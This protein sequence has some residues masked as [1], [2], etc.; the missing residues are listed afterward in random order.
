MVVFLVFGRKRKLFNFLFHGKPKYFYLMKLSSHFACHFFSF[1]SKIINHIMSCH[2]FPKLNSFHQVWYTYR[3]LIFFY[4]Y[5]MLNIIGIGPYIHRN[6]CEF[7]GM[8]SVHPR[9]LLK[10]VMVGCRSVKEKEELKY[11]SLSF[12]DEAVAPA[13]FPCSLW[14][15]VH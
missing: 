1:F 2:S 15:L 14:V 4:S 13:D 11:Y 3:L 12:W 6:P 8:N 7:T 10:G 9:E 5:L